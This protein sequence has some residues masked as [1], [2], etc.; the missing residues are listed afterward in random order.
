MPS[1]PQFLDHIRSV[2][3]DADLLYSEQE[4]EQAFD[5]MAVRVTQQ[6]EFEDPVCLC[7]MTGGLMPAAA[8]LKRLHFPLKVDYVHAT[9]YRGSTEGHE[10]EWKATPNHSLK[11]RVVL[12][13]DDILDGGVTL[14]HIID[15]CYKQGAKQV[16]TA[17]LLEKRHSRLPDALQT[18]NFVGLYIEDRYVFGYGMD[19]HEYLRNMPGIYAVADHHLK[20]IV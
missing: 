18:A 2:L 14:A 10:L 16:L 19:Y 13:V 15:F 7:V 11:D 6:L 12:V 5:Q 20:K 17:V 4:V 1:D 8:L 9:R 3:A